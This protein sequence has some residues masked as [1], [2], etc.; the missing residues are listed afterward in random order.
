MDLTKWASSAH[1]CLISLSCS[2]NLAFCSSRSLRI[3]CASCFCACSFCRLL[4][5]RFTSS[6]RSC[7][8][9]DLLCHCSLLPLTVT[10]HGINC[11]NDQS[12]FRVSMCYLS[13]ANIDCASHKKA[14]SSFNSE[15][16]I[17]RLFAFSFLS[18]KKY[19]KISLKY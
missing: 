18:L 11:G 5:S 8:N 2:S 4:L 6:C 1:F 12:D 14:F 19:T 7:N 15:R 10:F 13:K 3:S 9:T 17:T 16:I